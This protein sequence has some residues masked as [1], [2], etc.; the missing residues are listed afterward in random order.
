M[1]AIQH[2]PN[3]L[4]E[5][6]LIQADVETIT[7]CRQASSLFDE[8]IAGSMTIQYKI[9]LYTE[10]LKD[11]KDCPNGWS[12]GERLEALRSRRAA[13]HA[14]LPKSKL[15]ILDMEPETEYLV[16]RGHFAWVEE[17]EVQEDDC[18]RVFQIQSVSRGIPL[19]EWKIPLPASLLAEERYFAM[20]PDEDL[21]V[22]TVCSSTDTLDRWTI[23]LLSLTTGRNHPDAM[24]PDLLVTKD[25]DTTKEFSVCRNYLALSI[26]EFG[27]HFDFQLHLYNWKTGDLLLRLDSN[28]FFCL[29]V[30]FASDQHLLVATSGNGL[31]ASITILDIASLPPFTADDVPIFV[32]DHSD[33]I[34]L[35]LVQLQLPADC[36]SSEFVLRTSVKRPPPQSLHPTLA[37]PA[38]F[39]D[40]DRHDEHAIVIF[41]E[42]DY[43]NDDGGNAQKTVIIPWLSFLS[44]MKTA[45]D[46]GRKALEW[47]DWGPQEALHQSE[48]LCH[49]WA[50]VKGAAEF[51][52]REASQDLDV[53]DSFLRRID[54]WLSVTRGKGK[55]KYDVIAVCDDGAILA[56]AVRFLSS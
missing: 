44:G 6:I 7:K 10:R 5:Q 12:I 56:Q 19:K 8:V 9:E 49:S 26:S 1:S 38:F 24:R 22:A 4:L 31:G 43:E 41:Q 35:A 21:L 18:L 25:L 2:L 42:I 30:A 45:R 52:Q 46:T 27:Q 54:A 11:G 29:G 13:L 23:K 40:P 50:L 32:G 17:G 33:L 15:A 28:Q 37:Q 14:M 36:A 55:G 16:T 39:P 51:L 53:L 34:P 47:E 3:E 48:K 20:F